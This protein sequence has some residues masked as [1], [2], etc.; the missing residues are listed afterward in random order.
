MSACALFIIGI[1]TRRRRGRGGHR[2]QRD[3]RRRRRAPAAEHARRARRSTRPASTSPTTTAVSSLGAKRCGVQVEQLVA[4]QAL[5]DLDACPSM[6]RPYG[7]IRPVQ[8]RHQRLDRADRRIVLVLPDRGDDLA[9]ARRQLRR[10]ATIGAM[11][12]SPSSARTGSKSSARQV[13]TSENRCRVTA[14]VSEMPRLSSS[15]AISAA[16]ACAVP[17]SITRDSRY[18]APGA[19]AGS[20]I[21]PARIARLIVTAG[22]FARLLGDDDD[23]VVETVASRRQTGSSTVTSSRCASARA[24][25]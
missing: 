15:S 5:D 14:I 17:R 19:S 13:Q 6:R 7:M 18:I 10:R 21:E 12:M 1:T 11:T 3:R 22:V 25:T 9:L 24:C 23:A 2:R 8:Q 16:D 4:R 20:Q